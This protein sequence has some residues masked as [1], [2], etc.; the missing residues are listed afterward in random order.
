M[1]AAYPTDGCQ[2]LSRQY[3]VY[4]AR[5]E[6]TLSVRRDDMIVIWRRAT[7]L[8]VMKLSCGR[9]GGPRPLS[10]L[11]QPTASSST[12]LSTLGGGGG[13]RS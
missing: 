13:A 8:S 11:V 5:V 4:F 9:E 2:P 6:E 10:S 12:D 1:H 3:F 7:S